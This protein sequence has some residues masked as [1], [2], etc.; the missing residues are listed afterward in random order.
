MG[1]H[2]ASDSSQQ[3][4]LLHWIFPAAIAVLCILVAMGAEDARALLKYDRLAIEGGDWWRLITGHFVHLG[5]S[6]LALNIAGL[7]LVWI[8][9]GDT[10]SPSQRATPAPSE[11][12]GRRSN[13]PRSG[14]TAI[15]P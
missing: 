10:A 5:L 7:L 15:A 2:K 12:T 8:L 1:L 14:V 13:D 11:P 3:K 6:H 4:R 9:A